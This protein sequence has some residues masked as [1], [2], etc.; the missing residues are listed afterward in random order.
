MF[1]RV[2]VVLKN[3][4]ICMNDNDAAIMIFVPIKRIGV[5]TWVTSTDR[6][7]LLT[8]AMSLGSNMSASSLFCRSSLSIFTFALPRCLACDFFPL[9]HCDHCILRRSVCQSYV[10]AA[11]AHSL[12]NNSAIV[13]MYC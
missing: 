12:S 6:V 8:G 9:H 2:Q 11:H 7:Y 5:A 13:D 3:K 1:V 10:V 4:S